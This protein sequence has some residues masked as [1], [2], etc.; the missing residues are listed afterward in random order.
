MNYIW[1]MYYEN[2]QS[3]FFTLKRTWTF[4]S[5]ILCKIVMFLKTELSVI[6]IIYH[7][8]IEHIS[9]LWTSVHTVL[10]LNFKHTQYNCWTYFTKCFD[11]LLL[12][13]FV[14]CHTVHDL[15]LD[16]YKILNNYTYK[17]KY[18]GKKQNKPIQVKQ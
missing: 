13:L 18:F 17:M 6:I 14:F 1:H 11:M 9:L 12:L 5:I 3:L 2:L 8:Y 16:F 10:N 4:M 7:F 15:C